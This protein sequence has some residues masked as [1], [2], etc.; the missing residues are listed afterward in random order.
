MKL[1]DKYEFKHKRKLERSRGS[2]SLVLGG[3]AGMRD[4]GIHTVFPDEHLGAMLHCARV[5]CI[6][7]CVT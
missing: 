3:G 6:S 1:I 7:S 2:P 5:A 4:R